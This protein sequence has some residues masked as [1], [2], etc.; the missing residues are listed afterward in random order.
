[1]LPNRFE[2]ERTEF[3]SRSISVQFPDGSESVFHLHIFFGRLPI[4]GIVVTSK[5]TIAQNDLDNGQSEIDAGLWSRSF[6]EMG[7]R[8]AESNES[9][10]ATEAAVRGF[11]HGYQT[12]M[13]FHE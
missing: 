11:W 13:G 2:L 5:L 9:S 12:I 4:F 8:L 1:M 7:G 3:A 10:R 6:I